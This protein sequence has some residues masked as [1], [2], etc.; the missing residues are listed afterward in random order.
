L[1]LERCLTKDPAERLRD[2]GDVRVHLRALEKEAKSAS[3]S[4]RA[5]AVGEAAWSP[6][7]A[8]EPRRARW[9]W[10]TASGAFAIAALALGFLYF[11]PKPAPAVPPMRF[12][13]ASPG[14]ARLSGS[15]AISPDGRNLAFLATGADNVS[16][17]WV[18]SLENLESR[19]LEGTEGAI[20]FPFWSLDSRYIVFQTPGKLNRIEAAGGPLSPLCD[21]A[22]PLRGGFWTSDNKIIIGTLG[23]GALL[24]VAGGQLKPFTT[25]DSK[26]QSD[27][28]PSLLPDGRHF[29]YL[30]RPTNS[31]ENGGIYGPSGSRSFNEIEFLDLM[32]MASRCL[33]QSRSAQMVSRFIFCK[34]TMGLWQP[35]QP[36][37]KNSYDHSLAADLASGAATELLIIAEAAS[38][39]KRPVFNG[40]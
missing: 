8:K 38:L 26:D 20:N 29:V 10:P 34:P 2:I 36:H 33:S 9:I 35:V 4:G 1:L 37:V 3:K 25:D 22:A 28:S 7:H 24:E 5:A 12:E 21:L 30:R 18:R 15:L 11:R 6:A 23:G 27:I 14:N 16:R 19:P 31:P 32:T 39:Q 17:L 13:I 40:G